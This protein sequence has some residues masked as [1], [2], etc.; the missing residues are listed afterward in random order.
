MNYHSLWLL[1]KDYFLGGQGFTLAK[2][3]IIGLHLEE[4]QLDFVCLTRTR[5]GWVPTRPSSALEPFGSVQ[6]PAPWSLKQFLEWL[7]V[8]P[9]VEGNLFPKKRAIY[10]TLPRN[11][12]FARDLQLPPMSME[13]AL[14]SVQ[15]SLSI[16]CHLPLEEIYYDI[17]LCRAFQGDINA[18][19]LYAPR[20]DMDEYITVFRE[21]G[22]LD[23][24]RGLFP[25]SFGMGA[26][27]NLHNYSMPLGLIFPR[28][29][30]YELAVYQ[31]KGCL[32]SGT[33]PFS[34]GEKGGDLLIST[35]K[36]K[37]QGLGDN[38]FYFNNGGMP[39]LPLPTTNCLE[40]LPFITENL[41]IAAASPALCGLQEVSV[42]GNPPRLKTFRP[43]RV[44]APFMLVLILIISFL[45]C[46]ASWDIGRQE[47]NLSALTVEIHELKT[48]LEPMERDKRTLSKA[49]RFLED[50]DAFMKTKPRLFSH[51]NEIA[52]CL[53]EGAWFS[54]FDLKNGVMTLNGE[55]PDALKVIE[56]LRSSIM[57]DQV[58]L[59]GS[60]NRNITGAERFSLII[61][62]KDHE[63]GK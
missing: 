37:F 24:L 14:A 7:T 60:V 44:V 30:A 52:R 23:S 35:V 41:A 25:V 55:S 49:N 45:T 21:T 50:T 8:F 22:H 19:I 63:I 58:N 18:L 59:K 15:N 43:L 48:N 61:K 3:D 16:C 28:E 27:L 47:R 46:K 62:L 11:R 51:L 29:G 10:L 36:A 5:G 12:F 34:E 57:F 40:Q 13:D 26:W 39:A 20:K 42:D 6:E 56:A 9:L 32:F 54:R 38:V 2:N 33:W 1:V 31:K 4:G 53:P 17:H